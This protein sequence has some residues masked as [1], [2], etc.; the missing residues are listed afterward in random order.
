MD[1]HV[2][3]LDLDRSQPKQNGLVDNSYE[4]DEYK[5]QGKEEIF[6]LKWI[7]EKID[8]LK[9]T[10]NSNEQK[11][12]KQ[13]EY[14][15]T[16]AKD[17]FWIPDYIISEYLELIKDRLP[18]IKNLKDKDDFIKKK[19]WL[20]HLSV[21]YKQWIIVFFIK[22]YC[23]NKYEDISNLL[24]N[25]HKIL[26]LDL[27]YPDA[28]T[29]NYDNNL[30]KD[31]M[32]FIENYWDLSYQVLQYCS[33]FK[34]SY[35]YNS[36]Y[37]MNFEDWKIDGSYSWFA[38]ATQIFKIREIRVSYSWFAMATQFFENFLNESE[39]INLFLYLMK[40]PQ[41]LK[42]LWWKEIK[43]IDLSINSW[44]NFAFR[45]IIEMVKSRPDLTFP[46]LK[47]NWESSDEKLWS[48][49]RKN[50]IDEYEKILRAYIMEDYQD[51]KSNT[52]KESQKSTFDKIFFTTDYWDNG[53]SWV[54][55]DWVNNYTWN[56]I[57]DYSNNRKN[58][59]QN[60][61]NREIVDNEKYSLWINQWDLNVKWTWIEEE[62]NSLNYSEKLFFKVGLKKIEKEW[63]E[64]TV[65]SWNITRKKIMKT[66]IEVPKA[67][68]YIFGKWREK[69][70]VNIG[71][72]M[73]NMLLSDVKKYLEEHPNE[74]VLLCVEHHWG[75]N[76]SSGNWWTKKDRE[77]IANISPNLKIWSIR[78]Y[79]GKAL[80]NKN[81][82]NYKSPVSWFSNNSMTDVY[83]SDILN[84]AS[85]KWLWFHEMEIF[86]RL[87][88]LGSVA[89]LTE[90]MKYNDKKTWEIKTWKV[91][92][93]QNNKW[94]SDDSNKFA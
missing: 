18:N 90:Y 46:H 11:I 32:K 81:I 50:I 42:N 60:K 91:W 9:N 25:D 26:G 79:F 47:T 55:K 92:L 39:S 57:L 76:W 37:N 52:W 19:L 94:E 5:D 14:L 66:Y 41:K 49:Q 88:Y 43:E 51:W 4:K 2:F 16:E 44:I 63:Y 13:I 22:R 78:C 75:S 38:M 89:P 67:E 70:L 64:Y 68:I 45:W 30:L 28:I 17:T 93:A 6:S 1:N 3:P 54:P 86:T 40:N 65:E 82:Y 73:W 87:N 33:P 12:N 83:V 62:Y 27:F 8:N 53:L 24:L 61:A 72:G 85:K 23:P 71:K 36:I 10:V 15:K 59:N 56:S 34:W 31:T 7:K 69:K 77:E 29:W 74:K 48:Q 35:L 20:R 58:T 21:N 84:L 80:E